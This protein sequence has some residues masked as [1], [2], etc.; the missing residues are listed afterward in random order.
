[1]SAN[2]DDERTTPEKDLRAIDIDGDG[3]ADSALSERIRQRTADF[4]QRREKKRRK[5]RAKKRAQ[6]LRR[7]RTISRLK[8]SGANVAEGLTGGRSGGGSDALGS[9][10]DRLTGESG[11]GGETDDGQ[12]RGQGF[13]TDGDGEADLFRPFGGGSSASSGGEPAE[14]QFGIDV[15]IEEATIEFPERSAPSEQQGRG[16]DIGT[17]LRRTDQQTSQTSDR[18]GTPRLFGGLNGGED[19]DMPPLF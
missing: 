10:Q 14:R 2:N 15:T 17:E 12:P 8:E 18:D 16:L 13:D 11:G 19:D 3:E 1:M 5:K 6:S 9:L 7:K 4:A